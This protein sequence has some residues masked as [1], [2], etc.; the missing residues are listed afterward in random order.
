MS[1]NCLG[2]NVMPSHQGLRQRKN[3]FIKRKQEW[4][5]RNLHLEPGHLEETT[6]RIGPEFLM[7]V[8]EGGGM[9]SLPMCSLE[10][11]GRSRQ[12]VLKMRNLLVL[13]GQL[14]SFV[15]EPELAN[16]VLHGNKQAW[17]L[18]LKT[19]AP[20]SGMATEVRNMLSSMNSVVKS[21]FHT[22]SDGWTDIL[23]WWK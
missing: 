9:I 17:T 22:Y 7:T 14:K 19:H 8:S 12:S 6:V 16:L 5:E 4:K 1:R 21:E 15:E 2:P 10:I 3:T 13:N 18:T 11:I 20:S 23:C